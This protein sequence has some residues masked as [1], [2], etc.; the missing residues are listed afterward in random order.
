ML[1]Y[2]NN[3]L[4]TGFCAIVLTFQSNSAR[5]YSDMGVPPPDLSGVQL[6]QVPSVIFD[7][8]QVG[9]QFGDCTQQPSAKVLAGQRVLAR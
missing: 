8:P 6:P 2:N 1:Q 7:A 5:V 9:Y 4:I 3:L